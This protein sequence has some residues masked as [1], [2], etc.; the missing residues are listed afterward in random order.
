M[1]VLPEPILFATI[2]S[3]DASTELAVMVIEVS[4]VLSFSAYIPALP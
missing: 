4:E 2:P 3:P 1:T